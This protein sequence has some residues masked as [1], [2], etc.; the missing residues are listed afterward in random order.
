M[1]SKVKKSLHFENE[2]SISF[3][4]VNTSLNL[5]TFFKFESRGGKTNDKSFSQ[6]QK[7]S[8]AHGYQL[9]FKNRFGN[10]FNYHKFLEV[11]LGPQNTYDGVQCSITLK[12]SQNLPSQSQQQKH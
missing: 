5:K 11:D 7:W 10:Y 1:V 4:K 6:I 8:M 2:S 9:K 12:P 3:W